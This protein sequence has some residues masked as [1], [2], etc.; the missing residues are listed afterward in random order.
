MPQQITTVSTFVPVVEEGEMSRQ[1]RKIAER[2]N[3][4]STHA[5]NGWTLTHTATVTGTEGVMFID[6]LTRTDQH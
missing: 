2:D 5:N 3:D 4:L 6:T 1:L